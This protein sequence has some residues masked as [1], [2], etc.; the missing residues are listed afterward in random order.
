MKTAEAVI[1][2]VYGLLAGSSLASAV[3]GDIFRDGERPADRSAEDIVIIFTT[4]DAGQV[5]EGVVTLNIYIPDI[6]PFGDGTL[7]KDGA[8]AEVIEQAAQTW[9]DSLNGS[10]Q[11]IYRFRL[12]R[13]IHTQRDVETR[14]HFVV[15]S[16]GFKHLTI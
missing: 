11:D 4:A 14:Q 15:V 10:S 6:D 16:L 9:A 1:S 2:D 13:A 7:V 12:A 5:Q 3:G 8:R